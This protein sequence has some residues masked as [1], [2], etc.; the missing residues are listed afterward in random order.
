VAE[1]TPVSKL[2]KDT[3]ERIARLRTA[4]GKTLQDVAAGTNLATSQLSAAERGKRRINLNALE[5]IAAYFGVPARVLLPGSDDLEEHLIPNL[6]SDERLL[7]DALHLDDVETLLQAV[8]IVIQN[9]I[10]RI[11]RTA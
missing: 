1:K 11:T 5:D 9:K 2:S 6:N 8:G 10:D 4:R 3:G 7:L